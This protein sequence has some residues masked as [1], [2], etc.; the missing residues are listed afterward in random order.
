MAQVEREIMQKLNQKGFVGFPFLFSL[1]TNFS[2]EGIPYQQL[3]VTDLIGS[4]LSWYS[5]T[6]PLSLIQVYNI[7]I[8]LVS[9][10]FYYNLA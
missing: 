4:S 2:Y 7:G 5:K 6:K 3:L 8:Q 1:P 9:S 10:K